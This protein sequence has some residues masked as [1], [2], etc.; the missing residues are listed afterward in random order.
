MRNKRGRG[1]PPSQTGTREAILVAARAA[2]ARSG[3]DGASL[4]AIAT[5]AAVDPAL[6][7]HYF[8]SKRG[9]FIASVELPYGL[10]ELVDRVFGA[11]TEQAGARLVGVFLE[12]WSMPV[13]AAL[14]RSAVTDQPSATALRERLTR[15]VL[16]PIVRALGSDQP[17]WRAALAASH[18]AGLG[19]ARY[20]IGVEP[21]ASAPSEAV[22]VRVAP[23]IQHY[24]TGE[25]KERFDEPVRHPR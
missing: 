14:L 24:L 17:E 12:V 3:F 13:M 6:V 11:G 2:F 10:A 21:L 20:I 1:R 23:V 19:L 16:G 5:E 8:G 4:R 18:L 9:L 25:L 7:R 15:E 22:I